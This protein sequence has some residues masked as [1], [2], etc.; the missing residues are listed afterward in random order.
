MPKVTPLPEGQLFHLTFTPEELSVLS[1]GMVTVDTL[2]L[3]GPEAATEEMVM[4]ALILL[5]R[6]K[7]NAKILHDASASILQ[8]IQLIVDHL[9][10]E[11][12]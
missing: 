7:L 1:L 9:E 3:Q 4:G 11:M 8:K 10:K 12:K 5:H 6:S 2:F